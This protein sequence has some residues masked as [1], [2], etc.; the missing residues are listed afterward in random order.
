MEYTY[1]HKFGV[2]AW[3]ASGYYEYATDPEDEDS[4]GPHGW[5]F[6]VRHASLPPPAC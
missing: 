1:H 2:S 5:G 6:A 3:G 4:H